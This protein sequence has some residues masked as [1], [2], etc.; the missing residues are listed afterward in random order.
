MNKKIYIGDSVYAAFDGSGI[1]LTTENGMGATNSIYIE[2]NV[3]Q[4]LVNFADDIKAG[5]IEY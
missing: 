5:T 4:N 1:T 2:P 3:F